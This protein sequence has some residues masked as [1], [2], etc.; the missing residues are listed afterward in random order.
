MQMP[1]MDQQGR[2]Q[3]QTRTLKITIPAGILSGQQLD[4]L[5]KAAQVWGKVKLAIYI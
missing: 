2:V 1:E 5:N 4:W 3:Y